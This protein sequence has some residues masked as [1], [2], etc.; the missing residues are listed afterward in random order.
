MMKSVIL[1]AGLISASIFFSCNNKEN[2]DNKDKMDTTKQVSEVDT[3]K[4]LSEQFADLK[5]LRYRIPGFENLKLD[6]KKML[7]YLYEAALAGWD[8]HWTR[9]TNTISISERHL[10]QLLIL[11]TETRIVMIIRSFW[12]MQKEFSFPVGY[13]II[14]PI[15]K[16]Y[17]RFRKHI[18][19]NW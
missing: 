19:Q 15:S 3:F 16:F 4:Y 11:I 17:P 8:I 12:F 1:A 13:I 10:R 7:Y 5:I 18:L 2:V 6:E 14:I 9:I